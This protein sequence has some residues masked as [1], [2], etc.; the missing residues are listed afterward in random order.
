VRVSKLA[1]IL[2]TST[3]DYI[4]DDSG[5]KNYL[6]GPYRPVESAENREKHKNRDFCLEYATLGPYCRPMGGQ[7]GQTFCFQTF[8]IK[9]RKVRKSWRKIVSGLR[10]ITIYYVGRGWNSPPSPMPFRVKAR[11]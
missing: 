11:I 7:A 5:E 4:F 9:L 3:L 10:D 2:P 8:N 1:K 6:A